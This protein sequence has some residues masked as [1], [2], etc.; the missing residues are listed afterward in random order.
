VTVCCINFVSNCDCTFCL[1]TVLCVIF[2]TAVSNTV[3]VIVRVQSMKVYRE[4]RG[5]TP[6]ILNLST[7]WTKVV[8][9]AAEPLHTQQ[10]TLIPTEEDARWVPRAGMH[11]LEKR[12]ISCP[13]GDSS[14]GPSSPFQ[15]CYYSNHTIPALSN[16]MCEYKGKGKAIPLQALTG[17]EGS[18]RL[19]FPDFKTIGT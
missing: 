14:P 17:P 19:R 11:H 1:V 2:Q 13:C 4:R 8:N 5:R 9:T 10:R 6:F 18:R 3:M 7:R 12:R 15:P 16:T